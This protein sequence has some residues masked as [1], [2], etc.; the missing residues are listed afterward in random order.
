[1]S[2]CTC[3]LTVHCHVIGDSTV[4]VVVVVSIVVAL[5]VS[6]QRPGVLLARLFLLV[7]CIL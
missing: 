1:M 2:I 5:F 3:L 6:S 4:V 7:R